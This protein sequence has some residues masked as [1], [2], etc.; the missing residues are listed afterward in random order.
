MVSQLNLDSL[1]VSHQGCLIYWYRHQEETEETDHRRTLLDA[2]YVVERLNRKLRGWA[3]YFCLGPVSSTYQA[4]NIH[5][6]QRL[7]RET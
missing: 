3:N 1:R 4:I 6:T 7:R 5:V 2:E